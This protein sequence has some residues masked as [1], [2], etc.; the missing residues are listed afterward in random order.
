M[1]MVMHILFWKEGQVLQALMLLTRNKKLT[2]EN[3]GPFRSC[4]SKINYSFV[5]NSEE[6]RDVVMSMYNLLEH[7]NNYCMTSGSLQYYYRDELRP[8]G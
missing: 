3:N 4:T 5:D 6:D 7:S 2:F 1:I 8:S